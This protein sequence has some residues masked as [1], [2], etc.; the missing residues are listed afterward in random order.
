MARKIAEWSSR[1][2]DAMGGGG[3]AHAVVRGR[4]AEH[5]R[6]AERVDHEGGAG[7]SV[8]RMPH[9][10]RTGGEREH[11]GPHVPGAPEA[12]FRRSRHHRCHGEQGSGRDPPCPVA[13]PFATMPAATFSARQRLTLLATSVGLFMIFLDAT[14]VNV[15]LPDIQARLRRRREGPAVGR[16][17]L[18]PHDGHVHHVGGD[19]RRPRGRRRALH[20][21]HGAVR[22]GVGP[23]R[24]GARACWCSTSAAGSRAS[25]RR[26]QRRLAR[27]RR[28]RPS[29][30]RRPRRAP[31][32]SGRA[33]PRSAWPSVRRVGGVLTE[34]LGW[35]SI[36]FV[37]VGIAAVSA[38]CS[39][40]PSWTSRATRRRRRPRP[41]AAS[42]CSSSP[43]A[44]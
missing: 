23:V 37:N 17:R 26:R 15:A 41:P 5:R 33:S 18:Q 43:S 10:Q 36:F 30:I 8:G 31:S 16:R 9:E 6:H 3:P 28:A 34:T 29:R 39:C 11:E 24:A 38:S 4:H 12:G 22:R 20:R 27:A 32:A 25:A 19:V 1:P 13:L 7:A 2:I 40:G 21:R 42:S 14:I 44:H 35:R